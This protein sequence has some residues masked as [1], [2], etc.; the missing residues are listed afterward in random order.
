MRDAKCDN[1][2]VIQQNLKYSYNYE[3]TTPIYNLSFLHF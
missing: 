3:H 2:H 1:K